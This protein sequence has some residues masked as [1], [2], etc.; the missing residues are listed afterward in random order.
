MGEKKSGTCWER[1]ECGNGYEGNIKILAPAPLNKAG[2]PS[3]VTICF[4]TCP[5]LTYFSLYAD[6][7][8][9]REN[10]SKKQNWVYGLG[11]YR[12]L[13]SRLKDMTTNCIKWV[14][15]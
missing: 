4:N 5:E 10:K 7:I 12:M 9:I 8:I 2:T 14:K 1:G 11:W 13:L 15:C 6:D 3:V